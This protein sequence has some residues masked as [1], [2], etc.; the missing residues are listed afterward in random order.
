MADEETLFDLRRGLRCGR[1]DGL[2]GGAERDE[3]EGTSECDAHG[4]AG[5][6]DQM[7]MSHSPESA[8]NLHRKVFS[9]MWG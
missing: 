8:L 6:A 7:L 3:G 9:P 5:D 2:R 4:R 1:V